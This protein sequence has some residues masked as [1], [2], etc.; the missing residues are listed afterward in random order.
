V[1]DDICSHGR[2]NHQDLIREVREAAGMFAGAMPISPKE[3]FEQA[4][5]RI[6][7][8]EEIR[9]RV[10]DG[11]V[12]DRN[13]GMWCPT[14]DAPEQIYQPLRPELASLLW[15]EDPTDA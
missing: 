4:L 8:L 5:E 15:P 14:T 9:Q 11:W 6:R 12:P 3:A 10:A 13:V 2:P 1:S 7:A